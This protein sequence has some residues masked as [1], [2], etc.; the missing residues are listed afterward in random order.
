MSDY[1]KL[2]TSNSRLHYKLLFIF[3]LLYLSS[4]LCDAHCQLV[5]FCRRFKRDAHFLK[6][7]IEMFINRKPEKRGSDDD[8]EGR[9]KRLYL[10]WRLFYVLKLQFFLIV[11][12]RIFA[13]SAA[14]R[15]QEMK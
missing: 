14:Q 9:K 11:A 12:P 7:E 4:F 10:N 6:L 2:E 1:D 15:E 13:V 3:K 5:C 8:E